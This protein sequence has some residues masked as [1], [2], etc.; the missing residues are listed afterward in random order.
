MS[1]ISINAPIENMINAA[2]S[3]LEYII[4]LLLGHEHH[5]EAGFSAKPENG[6]SQALKS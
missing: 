1:K 3:E 5:G 4:A 6:K 2:A